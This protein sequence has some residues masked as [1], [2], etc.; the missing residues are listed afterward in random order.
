LKIQV[1]KCLFT[2]LTSSKSSNSDEKLPDTYQNLRSKIMSELATV[3]HVV[4]STN[5]W[6]LLQTKAYCCMTTLRTG[7]SKHL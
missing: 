5:I 6:K 4:I 7:N 2:L 3:E 1:L